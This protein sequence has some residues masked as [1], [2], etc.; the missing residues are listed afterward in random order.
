MKKLFQKH[1]ESIL[2]VL[3]GM[4]IF[5]ALNILM[6]QTNYALWTNAKVG[7]W[8]AFHKGFL[9]SGFDG[10]TYI[11]ISSWRPLHVL[12][13]HPLLSMMLWPLAE[14]NEGLKELTGMNCAIFIVATVWTIV[15]TCAWLLLYKLLRRVMQLTAGVS[16]LLCLFYFSLAYVMMATF[17]PDHMIL[18]MTTFLLMLWLGFK[19]D[20]KPMAAWKALVLSFVSMGIATTNIAKIWIIDMMTL[21]RR[22]TWAKAFKRS[23]LY[24]IPVALMGALYVIQDNTTQREETEHAQSI[25]A[26]RKA[27]DKKYAELARKRSDQIE[28][29]K[30]H[31]TI[32]IKLFDWTD[33][34]ISSTHSLWENVFGEGLILHEEHLLEDPN[35]TRPT[36]VAYGQWWKY[37][38]EGVIVLLFLAGAWCGRRNRLMLTTLLLMCFD[39]VMH[40][41]FCFAINDVYIMTAHWAYVIPIAIACLLKAT[42][43]KRWQNVSVIVVLAFV[44]AILW[45]NNASLIAE[46]ILK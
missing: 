14:V 46:H 40:L 2:V 32:D 16:L 11:I 29:L 19:N 13:R 45:W 24:L 28:R 30:S 15:S 35:K 27:T 4:I 9:F 31:K 10:P 26:K 42:Q 5:A 17:V 36:F 1:R 12:F 41:G 38:L 8:S 44:T 18:S 34:S 33:T 25:E 20:G 6:L 43:K 37:A 3:L 7:F 23:L 22:T 39:M 21:A